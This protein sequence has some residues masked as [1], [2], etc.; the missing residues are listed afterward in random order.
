MPSHLVAYPADY[1][2]VLELRAKYVLPSKSLEFLIGTFYAILV[3]GPLVGE[4]LH[5]L[6]R[7]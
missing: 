1:G 3:V 6:A 7:Y 4:E 5:N 2:V